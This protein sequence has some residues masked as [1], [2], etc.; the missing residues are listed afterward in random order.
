VV[1]GG[2]EERVGFFLPDGIRWWRRLCALEGPE[3]T[4]VPTEGRFRACPACG[5]VWGQLSP[6]DLRRVLDRQS[7]DREE[8]AGPPEPTPLAG[9][10]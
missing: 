8:V 3:S 5:L 6:A 9:R 7:H 1:T 4:A 10:G 2:V